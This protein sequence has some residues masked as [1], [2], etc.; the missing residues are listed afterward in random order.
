MGRLTGYIFHH[1][2]LPHSIASKQGTDFTVNEGNGL[3]L[4][5]STGLIMFP[6]TLKQLAWSTCGM[7]FSNI[8][9]QCQMGV[10]SSKMRRVLWIVTNI[11]CYSLHSQNSQVQESRARN[12]SSSS[13]YYPYWT[14]CEVFIF[15]V[16]ATL[17]SASI[18]ALVPKGEMLPPD[19]IVMVH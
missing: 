19:V 8:L 2:D 12:G 13:H 14:T 11:W 9:L 18:E 7:A 1:H 6:N 17:G 5:E 3:V 10:T 15:L 16:S 4:E